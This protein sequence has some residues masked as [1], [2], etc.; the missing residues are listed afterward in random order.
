MLTYVEINRLGG[1]EDIELPRKMS[2][3]ASGFDLYAAVQEDLVLEPGKRCLIPTG[4][5]IAMPAGLEAQIRPRSGLAL[6]HG[7]TC[8]NTPGTIDADYR[9]EIKVLLINLGEE[10]F[11]ITRNERIAQMVFQVVP[12][13]ELKQVDHLSETVRGAGGFGHTGR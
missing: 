12:E 7:I 9:G 13:V 4:F 1:N 11:T 10:P 6:K 3:L 5:A 2:E 8:L